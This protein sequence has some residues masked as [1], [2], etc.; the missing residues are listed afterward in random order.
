MIWAGLERFL[1]ELGIRGP[2]EGAGE[3]VSVEVERASLCFLAIEVGM[4]EGWMRLFTLKA[5]EGGFWGSSTNW[6]VCWG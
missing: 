6:I 4:G 2:R 5:L 3:N 1:G